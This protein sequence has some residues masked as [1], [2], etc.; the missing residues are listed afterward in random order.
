MIQRGI[1]RLGDDGIIEIEIQVILFAA[2]VDVGL[3]VR[4]IEL[5]ADCIE[6]VLEHDLIHQGLV[7]IG[8]DIVFAEHILVIDEIADVKIAAAH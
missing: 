1:G 5:I 8:D 4:D 3:R 2:V 6:L 7:D